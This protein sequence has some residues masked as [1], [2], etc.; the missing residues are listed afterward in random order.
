M[1]QTTMSTTD[2]ITINRILNTVAER[3]A[4]DIHFVV[5]NYPFLRI[6]G[7][8]V[9]MEGEQL[10][11][12]EVM[13]GIMNFF[14]SEEK[15]K[16]LDVTKDLK[17]IFDWLGKVRFRVHLFQ[18]KGQYSLSLKMI[19]G[20]VASLAD[21]ALPKIVADM[22]DSNQGLIF[23]TGP[24]NSGRSTTVAAMIQHINQTRSEHILYLGE[25]VEHLFVNDK[26]IIEQRE[27][28]VDVP[29]FAQGLA[30]AK[31]E[32]VNIVVTAKL[33]DKESLE[34]ALELSESGR[35]VIGILDYYSA[36][37]ALDGLVSE[38]TDAK[39][40]WA[41][42]VLA[43]FLV[44]VIVQRLVRAVD[45]EMTLAVEVLTNSPSG[46][47]L[48]KEG[49]FAQ[50]ESIIQTSKAEGMISLERSLVELVNRGKIKPE[51]AINN[52]VDPKS[53]KMLLRR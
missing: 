42:N 19:E 21:L 36:V 45:G 52:A 1:T 6:K 12:P 23:I 7:S 48:I 15:K 28:G 49:R 25:P 39:V 9:P 30:S 51:E 13:R 26:S 46:K 24:F 22:L 53:M 8:L 34:Q 50:L 18:Q 17:Y 32:D 29:T 35:L 14:V 31:D 37:T 40:L 43:D 5:G 2:T 38:F 20:R 44:G 16:I 4:T 10:I 47:A 33:P 11:T 3:K 41:R 27:V